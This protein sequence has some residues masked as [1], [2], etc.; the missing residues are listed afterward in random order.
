MNPDSLNLYYLG[1]IAY[2]P[3][4]MPFEVF[5]RRMADQLAIGLSDNWSQVC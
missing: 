2:N 5:A 3:Q 4:G 1:P